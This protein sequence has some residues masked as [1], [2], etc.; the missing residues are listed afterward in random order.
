MLLNR[1]KKQQSE[2]NIAT[3]FTEKAAGQDKHLALYKRLLSKINPSAAGDIR[4]FTEIQISGLTQSE[5]EAAHYQLFST[6]G[7]DRIINPLL[8]LE[9]QTRLCVSREDWQENTTYLNQLSFLKLKFPYRDFE[10]FKTEII[11]LKEQLS[12]EQSAE[13]AALIKKYQLGYILPFQA[14]FLEGKEKSFQPLNAFEIRRE[15]ELLASIPIRETVSQTESKPDS[16]SVKNEEQD[17]T[18][19]L[20][21]RPYH[22]QTAYVHSKKMM[23][24]LIEEQR[25]KTG[26]MIY[27]FDL[28]E[29][30]ILQTFFFLSFA[31]SLNLQIFP[32]DLTEKFQ[33]KI[34]TQH[35]DSCFLILM[36]QDKVPDFFNILNAS[37]LNMRVVGHSI[38]GDFHQIE[39]G[40]NVLQLPLH[41]DLRNDLSGSDKQASNPQ[42]EENEELIHTILYTLHQRQ[43]AEPIRVGILS[44][45][46][47]MMSK[48]IENS[49]LPENI[50]I[51]PLSFNLSE[52]RKFSDSLAWIAKKIIS[53][54]LLFI[55]DCFIPVEKLIPTH[56]ILAAILEDEK[57]KKSVQIYL[58]EKGKIIGYGEG[59]KALI[60]CGLLPYGRFREWGDTQVYYYQ[61]IDSRRNIEMLGIPDFLWEYYLNHQLIVKTED[62]SNASNIIM[63]QSSNR[64]ILGISPE[65]QHL[66][67]EDKYTELKY[68]LTNSL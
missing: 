15:I 48:V 59:N 50:I 60:E 53:L 31:V 46:A 27:F 29:Y 2:Q 34:L 9:G 13:F 65:I 23:L 38:S 54:D 58:Q 35:L 62:L 42:T 28:R 6:I 66:S 1:T 14:V 39:I 17:Y 55:P 57:I 68:F 41:V 43:S 63:H 20:L 4:L 26:K 67:A 47:N 61:S 7:L 32:Y 21:D 44:Y 11:S 30:S 3:I 36:P 45:F 8:L 52:Q 33:N 25:R 12:A 5:L 19:L 56:K 16:W 51:E 18:L 49:G 22:S 40:K 10:I 64:L 37:D 24:N